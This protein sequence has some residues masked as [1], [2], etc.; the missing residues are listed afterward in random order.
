M[1]KHLSAP[2]GSFLLAFTLA[3]CGGGGGGAQTPPPPA[4]TLAPQTSSA[5]FSF[6]LGGSGTSS[7]ARRAAYISRSTNGFGIRVRP[8]GGAFTGSPATPGAGNVAADVSLGSANCVTGVSPARVCTV[9]V[10]APVGYDDFEIIAWDAAPVSGTFGGNQ[11]SSVILLN[12]LVEVNQANA[13]AFTLNGVVAT[14]ALSLSPASLISGTASTSTLTVYAKDAVGNIIIAPGT[15]NDA[16][17]NPVT[18]TVSATPACNLGA[19]TCSSPGTTTLG[20]SS[21]TG[22]SVT[23]TTVTYNGGP[24][25]S[26]A[27]SV[28]APSLSGNSGATLTFTNTT[29]SIAIPGSPTITEFSN[30]ISANAFG[31]AGPY[32]FITTGPDGNLWFTEYNGGRVARMTPSGTVTEFST[33]DTPTGITSGP[34]GNLWFAEPSGGANVAQ[35]ERTTTSGTL[36][37]FSTGIT[38]HS[39]PFFITSGPDGNLWFTENN[40]PAIARMTPAGTVTE[41]SAGITARYPHAITSGPDGNVWFTESNGGFSGNPGRIG[42]ITMAGTITEFSAGVTANQLPGITTGPD[43]NL[44]FTESFDTS[45]GKIGRITTSGTVTEF[46]VGAYPYSITTAPD[47]NLWF[48]EYKSNKIGRITTSGIVTEFSNGITANSGPAGITVGPDGN[49][50]FTELTGNRIGRLV[51]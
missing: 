49:L 31:P 32:G 25:T 35:I 8:N 1:R 14:V 29:G 45:P 39:S 33:G 40:I 26:S 9:V 47:G 22:P 16:N 24:L 27:F 13:I 43:G 46:T 19:P 23:S 20:V 2:L 38:S 41:F 48:A 10:P 37:Q 51:P 6:S 34:D 17:G 12:Q 42:R 3:G 30:G 21:F 5:R 44:W 18:V 36:T 11:L 4:H 50:W 15:Y 7:S 28:T